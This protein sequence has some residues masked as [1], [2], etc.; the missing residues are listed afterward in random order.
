NEIFASVAP[1]AAVNGDDHQV[2]DTDRPQ[3][4]SAHLS[5]DI[6]YFMEHAAGRSAPYATAMKTLL[7]PSIL[8]ADLSQS[9]PAGYLGVETGGKLGHL[10]GGRALSD[11]VMDTTLGCIFGNTLTTIGAAP[12][13]SAHAS[14]GLES[15]NVTATTAPKHY[16]DGSAGFSSA[17]FPYVGPPQ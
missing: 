13:D 17:S 2:N 8:V 10:F 11:G 3:D 7:G 15:D 9:G 5:N 14:P 12:D 6:V 1:D 16:A 4:D